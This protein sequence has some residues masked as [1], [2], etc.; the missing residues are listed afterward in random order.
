MLRH[1]TEGR[2][3]LRGR[4]RDTCAGTASTDYQGNAWKY[5][6]KGNL[7]D[8]KDTEGH[9]VART[10]QVLIWNKASAAPRASYF[11]GN[12]QSWSLHMSRA[13]NL[14]RVHRRRLQASAFSRHP[15]RGAADRILRGS[16]GELR[17]G[18]R[19]AARTARRVARTLC[20]VGTRRRAV[21]WLDGAAHNR[22]HQTVYVL[23]CCCDRYGPES[24]SEHLG[25]VVA[26][27]RIL[28]R[29]ADRCPIHSRRWRGSPSISTRCRRRSDARCCWKIRLRTSALPTARSRRS[30]SS[31]KCRSEPDAGC[32]ST[33]TT[34]L[35][36]QRTTI[37]NRSHIWTRFPLDRVKEVHLGGHDEETDDIGAPLLIDTHGS[38]IA[39]AV[40]TLYAHVIARTGPIPTL[41]EWDMRADLKRET[42]KV[43]RQFAELPDSWSV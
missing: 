6:A 15:R 30:T 1:R 5:V 28:K 33:S 29:P 38:P 35:C 25:L 21:N 4:R 31:P 42:H 11:L 22:D 23:K 14:A 10:D 17:G 41:I 18:R 34:F 32:C 27:R 43:S 40:W 39:E 7:P 13:S 19:T 24:F 9:R 12:T 8:H 26:R 2:Q 20:V 36:R 16:R 37:R 3:R